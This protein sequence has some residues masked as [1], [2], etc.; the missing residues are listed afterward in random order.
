MCFVDAWLVTWVSDSQTLVLLFEQ[1]I[2]LT[3]EPFIQSRNGYYM[4][5]FKACT[6]ENSSSM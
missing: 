2:L 5:C 1:Q 3:T 4:F 6:E